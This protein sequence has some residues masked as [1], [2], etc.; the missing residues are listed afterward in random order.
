MYF[1][2]LGVNISQ[3]VDLF[4][5]VARSP[6]RQLGFLVYIPPATE[7]LSFFEIISGIFPGTFPSRPSGIVF[8]T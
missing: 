7:N 5:A 1:P 4:T 2:V 3:T 6:L 8:T